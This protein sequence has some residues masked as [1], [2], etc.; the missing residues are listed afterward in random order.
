VWAFVGVRV[1]LTCAGQERPLASKRQGDLNLGV[2]ALVF[3]PPLGVDLCSN[4]NVFE[5]ALDVGGTYGD[6]TLFGNTF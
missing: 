4:Q 2:A 1:G 6:L 5:A 3:L